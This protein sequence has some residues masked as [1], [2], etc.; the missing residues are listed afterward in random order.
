MQFLQSI[1][2][3][4]LLGYDVLAAPAPQRHHRKTTR[5]FKVPRVRRDDYIPHG[6]TAL[7]VAYQKYGITPTNL[8]L[9]L[10]DFEPIS[11][12]KYA[13]ELEKRGTVSATSAQGGAEYVS[14]VKIGGQTIVMNFDTGS[15]DL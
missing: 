8:E 15:S 4:F 14:P 10:L 5:S 11:P 3:F 2:L 1:I 12:E 9:D 6:P 13:S 7:R